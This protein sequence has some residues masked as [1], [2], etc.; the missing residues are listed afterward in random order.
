M[1]GA[2]FLFS[3]RQGL[4][5]FVPR[6]VQAVSPSRVELLGRRFGR[7]DGF[8]GFGDLFLRSVGAR[9]R[10]GCRLA[11]RSETLEAKRLPV[12]LP[13]PH[14]ARAAAN[15]HQRTDTVLEAIDLDTGEVIA[16]LRH[17]LT[18]RGF[19]DGGSV[20]AIL[21]DEQGFTF[22]KTWKLT[23]TQSR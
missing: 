18:F 11:A 15:Q 7:F 10:I 20:Y 9:F 13:V 17:D 22:V 12:E 21:E 14:T 19:L 1:P 23:L 2:K 6:D 16:R 3:F 4:G 5:E 8:G